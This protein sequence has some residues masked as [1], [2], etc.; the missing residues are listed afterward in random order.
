MLAVVDLLMRD[1]YSSMR[2]DHSVDPRGS[3]LWRPQCP[4]SVVALTWCGL[5]SC[6]YQPDESEQWAQC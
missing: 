6:A 3:G 5:E 1:S 2:M 4:R